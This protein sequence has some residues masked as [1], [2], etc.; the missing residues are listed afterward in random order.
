MKRE[1]TVFGAD[2]FKLAGIHGYNYKMLLIE[3]ELILNAYTDQTC[4]QHNYL[5]ISI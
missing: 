2:A 5:T 4:H 1:L 3:I